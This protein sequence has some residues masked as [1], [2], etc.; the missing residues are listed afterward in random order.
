MNDR[1]SVRH[2]EGEF[3]ARH[4]P[5]SEVSFSIRE[6]LAADAAAISSLM[7]GS[8][9]DDLAGE[10]SVEFTRQMIGLWTP[11]H[12]AR[13]LSGRYTLVACLDGHVIGTASL[14]QSSIRM[15]AVGSRYHRRGVGTALLR[16]LIERAARTIPVLSV[17]SILSAEGFYESR[18]F[19]RQQEHCVGGQRW[20]DMRLT[21]GTQ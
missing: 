15:V 4:H 20:V 18:G 13:L 11:G 3:P 7:I 6:A 21:L 17:Q 12:V 5:M 1:P 19:D 14:Y 8:F 9:A 2:S 10:L 16:A